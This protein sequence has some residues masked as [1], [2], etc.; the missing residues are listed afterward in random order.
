MSLFLFA[1]LKRGN[2]F[3]IPGPFVAIEFYYFGTKEMNKT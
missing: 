2:W 3:L 1:P